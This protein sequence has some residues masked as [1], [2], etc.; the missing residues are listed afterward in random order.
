[1][2][3]QETGAELEAGLRLAGWALDRIGM[4]STSWRDAPGHVVQVIE[5]EGESAAECIRRFDLTICCAAVDLQTHQT[6]CSV[7]FLDDVNQRCL[8][9]SRPA[10][11]VDTL[12]RI[13][14]FVNEGYSISSTQ[15]QVLHGCILRELHSHGINA[16]RPSELL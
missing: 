3:T 7:T 12:R 4:V 9:I 10:F 11:P 6:Y 13:A 2:R 16:F 5:A 8:V 14:R 15:L 1:V